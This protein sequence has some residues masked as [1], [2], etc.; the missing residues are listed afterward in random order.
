M[1]LVGESGTGKE[2]FAQSIHNASDRS[3][4][5]FVA[6]NC[7]AAQ[8]HPEMMAA[9]GDKSMLRLFESFIEIVAKTQGEAK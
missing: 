4:R 3:K 2:L 6:F 8:W 7:A 9:D 5:P 1:L